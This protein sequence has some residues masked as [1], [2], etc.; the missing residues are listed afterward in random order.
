[1]LHYTNGNSLLILAD[2]NAR[3]KL[4]YDVINNERRKVLE[5]FITVT[6]LHIINESIV[7]PT[8]E[9]RLGRSC[10]DLTLSNSQLL[11]NITAW[12]IGDE[13]SCSGHKL[14]SFKIARGMQNQPNTFKGTR[15]ITCKEDY[16][17]L[18]AY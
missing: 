16:E 8:F 2:T 5:E 12:N 7:V 9:A 13:E 18:T 15:Y 1:M 4:W 17:S 6:N 11:G 14:I 3:S 10:I